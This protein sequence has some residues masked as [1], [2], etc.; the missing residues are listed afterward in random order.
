MWLPARMS[1]EYQGAIPRINNP[2]LQG[3]SHSAAT[4]S[5]YK[6]FGTSATIVGPKKN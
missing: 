4:Y 6:R 2:P 3:T 5:D 1:E